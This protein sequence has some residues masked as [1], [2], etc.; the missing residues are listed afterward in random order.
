[1]K[2]GITLQALLTEVTRQ[3]EVK[4]DFVVGTNRGVRLLSHFPDGAAAAIIANSEGVEPITALHLAGDQQSEVFTVSDHCHSQ[5]AGRLGIPQ[6]YYQRLLTDHPDILRSDVNNL[7][8]REPKTRLVRTLDGNARAFLSDRFRRLDNYEVLE[9]VLPP[10]VKGDI[11]NRLLSSHVGENSMHLKI[12]FTD[13]SLIREIGLAP[14]GSPDTVQP[15]CVLRNSETGMGKLSVKAGFYRDYCTNGCIFGATEAFSWARNHIGGKLVEGTE[16]EVF[17]DE[18]QRLQDLTIIAEITDSIR[19]M[20]NPETITTMCNRLREIKTG[21]KVVDSFGAVDQLAIEVGLREPEK[22]SVLATLLKDDDF[23]QWG[24]VNAVT[25][26]ANQDDISYERA[27][28][29]EQVGA[30][31]IEFTPRKWH[32][33]ASAEKLAA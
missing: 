25:A 21:E 4:R 26:T 5:I 31:I 7:F 23:S 27:Q 17:T 9:N 8:N 13:E 30:K 28:E 32:Q 19:A 1:M 29:L 2:T 3:S 18:T 24:M 12:L 14:N 20:V 11:E 6:K 15:Y 10:L 33:V 16:I 22:L